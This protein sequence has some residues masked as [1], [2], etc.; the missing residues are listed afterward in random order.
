MDQQST[1]AAL[2]ARAKALG[3]PMCDICR[4]AG[5]APS[6]VS[7]WKAETPVGMTFKTLGRLQAAISKFEA[8]AESAAA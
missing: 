5:V 8:R 3:I 4:E 6:T 2:E 1:I 7:R